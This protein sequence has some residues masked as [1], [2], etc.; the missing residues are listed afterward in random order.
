MRL[1][2]ISKQALGR[3][4]RSGAVRSK[5]P[6]G[7]KAQKWDTYD[8]VYINVMEL[9]GQLSDKEALK[10]AE[11]MVVDLKEFIEAGGSGPSGPDRVL[12]ELRDEGYNT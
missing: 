8:T 11:E 7:R 10:M 2:G 9:L 4:A 12:Q 3:I 1:K 6:G 5:S